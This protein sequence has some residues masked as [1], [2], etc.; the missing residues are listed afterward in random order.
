MKKKLIALAVAGATLAPLAAMAQ[1]SNPV[2]LY[3]R[4]YATFESVK[5]DGGGAT[6]LG[7]RN[8]VTDQSSFFGIRGTEDLGGGLKA[9]FQLESVFRL[10]SNNSTF[11]NR[12]SGVGLQGGFGSFLLGRW[13]TPFKVTTTAVDPFGDLTIGGITAVANDRGNFDRREQNTVQYWSPNL[14]GFQ[15]RAG[16]AA[17]EGKTNSTA[18]TL[19]ANPSSLSFSATY[20]QGPF[21][22]GYAWERHKD[23][24][25]S[26][27]SPTL[28]A[29]PGATEKGQAL[30][31]TFTIG[32]VKLG[33]LTQYFIKN[34][35]FTP[36]ATA[37][38]VVSAPAGLRKNGSEAQ[39]YSIVYTIGKVQL[40][41]SHQ[42]AIDGTYGA[43]LANG[44]RPADAKS[45]INN[46][47]VQYNFTRRTFALAQYAQVKNNTLGLADIAGDRLGVSADQDPKGL[48]FG[49]RHLF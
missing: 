32:P 43:L 40:I 37:G 47:G 8:R 28:L 23:Q 2:T 7:T 42:R 33:V 20:T 5:A 10:D 19:G 17:N 22:V 41:A 34:T 13:D 30:F 6:P 3:G 27:T 44:A 1:T 24:W 35:P 36:G 39:L 26:Y 46:F 21:Y 9:F 16:Y 38:S 18:T 4:A 29:L 15:A 12:N 14:G 25:K 11:A 45:H 31:G 48:S 49:L